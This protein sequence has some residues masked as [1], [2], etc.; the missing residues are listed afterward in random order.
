[1]PTPCSNCDHGTSVVHNT[2]FGEGTGYRSTKQPE[3]QHHCQHTHYAVSPA[4]CN[5]VVSCS[6]YCLLMHS[7]PSR[8]FVTQMFLLQHRILS[9]DPAYS[10]P[11]THTHT[12][13]ASK[14]TGSAYLSDQLR[15]TPRE[16]RAPPPTDP[17][18]T[19]NPESTLLFT[20]FL[21][22]PCPTDFVV[23]IG[24]EGIRGAP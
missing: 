9:H 21:L 16:R 23:G 15:V 3:S 14:T 19:R 20:S 8:L 12:H 4:F 13:C 24:A 10:S 6:G 17:A 2:T 5:T 18:P 22:P 1:M 7:S 11:A